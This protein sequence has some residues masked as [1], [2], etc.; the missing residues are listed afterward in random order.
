EFVVVVPRASEHDGQ[1]DGPAA[2]RR[3][4]PMR[5]QPSRREAVR[6]DGHAHARGGHRPLLPRSPLYCK[7]IPRSHG[8]ET[9]ST[10][11]SKVRVACRGARGLVKTGKNRKANDNAFA[12]AA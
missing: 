6:I 11:V 3:V 7:A 9:V 4:R 5:R 1:I 8:G 10:G 12:L 2:G